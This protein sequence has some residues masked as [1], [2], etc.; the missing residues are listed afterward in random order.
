MRRVSCT[1]WQIIEHRAAAWTDAMPLRPMCMLLTGITDTRRMQSNK[2]CARFLRA[3]WRDRHLVLLRCCKS[4]SLSRTSEF[5]A[6]GRMAQHSLHVT[7]HKRTV[8][9]GLDIKHRRF[10]HFTRFNESSGNA[11][12]GPIGMRTHSIRRSLMYWRR[13]T[14]MQWI[15]PTVHMA[16]SSFA[17]ADRGTSA[18]WMLG[19]AMACVGERG[20]SEQLILY[21]RFPFY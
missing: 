8:Q 6:C 7:L 11:S 14:L 5:S 19:S 13:D 3:K 17:A 21:V 20:E 9:N 1:K 10:G 4:P 18:K 12:H 16:S 15:W 2:W